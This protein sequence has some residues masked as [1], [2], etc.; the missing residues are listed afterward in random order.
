MVW[1]GA[2]TQITIVLQMRRQEKELTPQLR[3]ECRWWDSRTWGW[4]YG[5]LTC[6]PHEHS[7]KVAM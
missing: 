3:S 4:P 6:V 1:W 5:C 7:A 2:N